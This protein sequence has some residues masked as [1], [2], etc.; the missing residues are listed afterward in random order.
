MNK[1]SKNKHGLL[2]LEAF[3]SSGIDLKAIIS[4]VQS[5]DETV[6]R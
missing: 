1:L 6:N 5:P 2:D 4:K 3:V